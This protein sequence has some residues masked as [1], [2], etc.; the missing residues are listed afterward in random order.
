MKKQLFISILI[1]SNDF[2]I[3]LFARIFS[4]QFFY[5][6]HFFVSFVSCVFYW[7]NVP[8][9]LY[10]VAPIW[11]SDRT[12]W[13]CIRS[14]SIMRINVFFHSYITLEFTWATFICAWKL[15]Y[16][17]MSTHMHWKILSLCE[18]SVNSK[19]ELA[20]LSKMIFLEIS[21]CTHVLCRHNLL[22]HGFSCDTS[23]KFD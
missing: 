16:I 18:M 20:N 8:W 7:M 17:R 22:N 23:N 19:P 9:M 12:K 2:I 21:C 5:F 13:T 11:E 3:Y 10:T 4:K 6:S 15:F 1:I 14:N